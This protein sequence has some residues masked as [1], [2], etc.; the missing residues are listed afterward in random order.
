MSTS[1]AKTNAKRA[2]AAATAEQKLDY[3]ARAIYE[4]ARSISDIEDQVR[5][6]R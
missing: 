6:L 3:I 4:L 5:R 2:Q 1:S